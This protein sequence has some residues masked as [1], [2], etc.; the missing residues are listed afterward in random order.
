MTIDQILKLAELG[1]TKEEIQALGTPEAAEA[2]PAEQE[3]E[4]EPAPAMDPEILSLTEAMKGYMESMQQTLK[5]I[6]SANIRNSSM[7]MQ[8]RETADTALAAIIQPTKKRK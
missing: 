8:D 3:P 6:R 7:P 5:D 1:Y 2:A 4:Q